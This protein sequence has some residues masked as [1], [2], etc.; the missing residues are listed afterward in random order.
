MKAT[1]FVRLKREVLDPQGDAV[2]RALGTLGF[3]GVKDVRIGKL[4]E[5]ELDPATA[6]A[7]DLEARLKKMADEMLANTVIE[8]YEVK[9]ER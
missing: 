8:D 3:A 2:R 9:L 1:V 6:A 7:P 5:I 4:I